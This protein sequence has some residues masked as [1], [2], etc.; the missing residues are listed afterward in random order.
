MTSIQPTPAI[1]YGSLSIDRNALLRTSMNDD[2]NQCDGLRHMR[3]PE[4]LFK[5]GISRSKLYALKKCGQFPQSHRTDH[6]SWFFARDIHEWLAA[7]N[8]PPPVD[9]SQEENA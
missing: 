1:R 6:V 3:L 9:D 7:D 2:G 5:T 8:M 4:V